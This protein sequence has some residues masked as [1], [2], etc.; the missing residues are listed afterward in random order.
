MNSF[1]IFNSP[2]SIVNHR[3][4][5]ERVRHLV[6]AKNTRKLVGPDMIVLHYTA[7]WGAEATAIYLTR[8]DVG[9]SA[10]LVVGRDGEII[11][12]VPFDTEAWHAGRSWYAGRSGLN[13]YSIGIELDNLGMLRLSGGMF[14]AECGRV[15]PAED[16]FA[17]ES[18][19]ELTYWHRYTRAQVQALVKICSVLE[20]CYPIRDVVGH[21]AVTNR[22]IDPGPAL[23]EAFKNL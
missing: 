23:E 17:H 7:A 19:G 14:V 20:E 15:V 9:A 21:S 18:G 11:Q 3:L 10:H 6:C 2:F 8:P 12:L 13:R 5:G 16:V 1:S 22:K 4:M